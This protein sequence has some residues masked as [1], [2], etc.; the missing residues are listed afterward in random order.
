MILKIFYNYMIYFINFTFIKKALEMN[1]IKF[2][3]FKRNYFGI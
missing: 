3:V 2:G 1:K